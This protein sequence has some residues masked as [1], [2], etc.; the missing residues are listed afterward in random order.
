MMMMMM[1]M[2]MLMFEPS[3]RWMNCLLMRELNLECV[4]RLW[5]A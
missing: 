2:M 5:D 3:V 1:M 4:L